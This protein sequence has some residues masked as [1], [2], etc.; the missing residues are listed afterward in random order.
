[1]VAY[2]T[3]PFTPGAASID[4]GALE[5]EHTPSETQHS[6]FTTAPLRSAAYA[7]IRSTNT[8]DAFGNQTLAVAHGCVSGPECPTPG[9]GIAEREVIQSHTVPIP[10]AGDNSGWLWR[11]G[12]SWVDS[13]TRATQRNHTSTDFDSRGR[14]TQQHI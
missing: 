8:V 11:T 12:E 9:G 4:I 5:V 14:P 10:I 7:Q 1:A 6:T 2:D 3:A 13:T